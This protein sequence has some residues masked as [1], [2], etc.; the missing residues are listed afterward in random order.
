MSA[1]LD[2]ELSVRND[3]SAATSGM[4]RTAENFRQRHWSERSRA[5]NDAMW[6]P[7]ETTAHDNSEQVIHRLVA[8]ETA[9]YEEVGTSLQ[10]ESR[11]CVL[12]LLACCLT[13]RI[14]SISAQPDGVLL[15]T[16][17]GAGGERLSVRCVS[18][19]D[20]HFSLIGPKVPAGQVRA[21]AWGNVSNPAS[22]WDENEHARRVA[23]G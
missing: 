8:I 16:W 21:H 20:I 9:L 11:L 19:S 18:N 2:A 6:S 10:P 23:A 17:R 22:F 14:P 3:S 1:T 12:R 4:S 15:C 7:G 5:T 13:L